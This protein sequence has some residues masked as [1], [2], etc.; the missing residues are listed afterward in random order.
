ME[1]M[2]ARKYVTI[3]V[4]IEDGGLALITDLVALDDEVLSIHFSQ[5]VDLLLYIPLVPLHVNLENLD[6]IVVFFERIAQL[7][8]EITYIY[9][10]IEVR[11][12]VLYL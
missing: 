12:Y 8:F 4:I 3:M 6:F 11:E 7:I 2:L 9:V 1:S 5:L 10:S